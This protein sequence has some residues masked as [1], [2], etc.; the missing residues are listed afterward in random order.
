[1]VNHY[2]F[3]LMRLCICCFVQVLKLRGQQFLWGG[4]ECDEAREL[5]Q[6]LLE[7]ERWAHQVKGCAAVTLAD[8]GLHQLTFQWKHAAESGLESNQ[9]LGCSLRDGPSPEA[10]IHD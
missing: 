3:S 9:A 4:R 7:V 6:E 10:I 2:L 1:M 8:R 5:Q